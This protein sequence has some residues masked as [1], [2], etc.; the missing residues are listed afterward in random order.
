MYLQQHGMQTGCERKQ[1]ALNHFVQRGT[2]LEVSAFPA[3]AYQ[4]RDL[5][6]QILPVLIDSGPVVLQGLD[7]DFLHAPFLQEQLQA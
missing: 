6:Q 3:C 1:N 5:C 2:P 4:C 7:H